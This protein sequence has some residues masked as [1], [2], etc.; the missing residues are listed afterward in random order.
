MAHRL[1]RGHVVQPA[2]HQRIAAG[3]FFYLRGGEPFAVDVNAHPRR[4]AYACHA[5]PLTP[6]V[7]VA[8]SVAVT[9]YFSSSA[10]LS[11]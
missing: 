2:V 1:E 3:L 7:A 6:P 11:E 4:F 10:F 9:S 5:A 8:G